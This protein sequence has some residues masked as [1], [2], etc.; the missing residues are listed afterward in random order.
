MD[1]FGLRQALHEAVDRIMNEFDHSAEQHEDALVVPS[2]EQ[3]D[4]FEF[5]WPD[6]RR[7]HMSDVRAY[8]VNEAGGSRKVLLART[9]RRAW[10]R[11]RGRAVVFRRAGTALYPWT[12]FVETEDGRY[13]A[14]I[15]RA[16]RPRALAMNRSE[17]PAGMAQAD[18]RRTD[19]LFANVRK[20][21]SLRIVVTREDEEAMVRHGCL[22]ARVR[23]HLD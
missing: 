11:Q 6:G 4:D 18:I 19:E 7:E 23:N 3:L 12:E 5:L 17:L 1:S 13:A 20:G 2:G 10:G 22:V 16:D 21:P 14:G 15:P 9:E 8:V